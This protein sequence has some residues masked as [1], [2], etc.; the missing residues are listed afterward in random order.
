M[1][2]SSLAI[3]QKPREK[4]DPTSY[5]VLKTD[6]YERYKDPRERIKHHIAFDALLGHIGRLEREV[7]RLNK[8]L[9]DREDAI[10]MMGKIG[11][12]LDAM[13]REF[14][15][16]SHEYSRARQ[17]ILH[18]TSM[19]RK[20]YDCIR[21]ERGLSNQNIAARL[22]VSMRMVRFHVQ[23]LLTKTGARSKHEL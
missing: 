3:V 10:R 18:F 6:W 13:G 17:H 23:N 19:E 14:V 1:S 5:G 22:G 21:A 16:V 20:V 11:E 15:V 12:R 4:S 9:M 7:V 2:K 8:A